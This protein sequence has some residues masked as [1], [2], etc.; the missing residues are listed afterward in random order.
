MRKEANRSY[1]GIGIKEALK[2]QVLLRDELLADN[3]PIERVRVG[4][5]AR[6]WIKTKKAIVDRYTL[7][8]YA[9][10]LDSHVLPILGNFFYDAVGHLEVQGMVNEL[11]GKRK[12]NGEPY[13]RR[14]VEDFYDVF[15]NMTK[16]AIAH[17][18]LDRDPTLRI[19]FG[20]HAHRET[21]PKA[22]MAECLAVLT[23]MK[24][25]RPGSFALLHTGACTGQRFC[26]VSALKWGDVDFDARL[27]RFCRKQVRGVVGPIS[28]KKPAPK[29]TPLLPELQQT[30]EDHKERMKKLGYSTE[31]DAWVFPS[32]MLTLKQPSALFTALRNSEKDAGVTA[33]VT[34]HRMRYA[35]S[36]LLRLAGVDQV[37]RRLMIGHVTEEM[38]EHYSSVLMDEKRDAMIAVASKLAELRSTAA[39]GDK[40]GDKKGDTRGDTPEKAK[41]A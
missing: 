24:A 20:N 19:S 26:H 29:E 28:K 8:S 17:L 15:R 23:A 38:Q 6:S 5:F 30:L 1:E 34:P 12:K 14:S 32:R 13:A 40:K 16:D 33:H 11:L 9:E 39:M 31:A 10:A 25:K 36:D 37:T 27:I 3:V 4:E 21:K 2:R 18:N 35:F 7:T 41:A 22:T